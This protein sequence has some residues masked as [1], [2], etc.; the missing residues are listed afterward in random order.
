MF[1]LFV[2]ALAA[3]PTAGAID[4]SRSAFVGCLREA[5]STAKPPEV[6]VDGFAAYAKGRCTAQE[7][8]LKSAMIAF[9]IKNGASRRS[10]AEGAQFTIDDFIETARGNYA[11]RNSN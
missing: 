10:A 8:A 7:E 1:S 4:S 11:A 6:P 9:D 3:A 2:I 5:A